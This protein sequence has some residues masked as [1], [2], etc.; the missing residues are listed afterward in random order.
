MFYLYHRIKNRAN[1]ALQKEIMEHKVTVLKLNESE[2]KFRKLAEKSRQGIFIVQEERFTYV[3]PTLLVLF[4]Y[5]VEE[6]LGRNPL[7]FVFP[8]DRPHMGEYIRRK[9]TGEAEGS[10]FQFRGVTKKGKIVYMESYGTQTMYR[11]KIS[12]IGTITDITERKKNEAELV[13]SRK[14]EAL[15]IL[16]GGVAHDF[17]NLLGVIVGYLSMI[18]EQKS[19]QTDADT[20]KMVKSVERAV[21]QSVDLAAKFLDLSEGWWV[22]RR[23]LTFNELLDSV[24]DRY[25]GI[26][27]LLT[28]IWTEPDLKSFYGDERRLRDVFYNLVKNADEAMSDPKELS[29]RGQNV[30]LDDMNDHSLESGEYIQ[31]TFR[32]NGKGIPRDHLERVFDPYFST[33]DEHSRKGMGLGLAICNSILEKHKG[34]IAIKSREGEGTTVCIYIPTF[35]Q[36]KKETR[37]MFT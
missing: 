30:D 22:N 35:C 17:N 27:H 20:F 32:D 3:N 23:A 37:M 36:E 9:F 7:D 2:E 25:P 15:G 11:G 19:I 1:Q 5:S 29:I 34:H 16:A 26:S 12:L 8:G 18:K 14:T 28:D 13:R 6:V 4:G 10:H 24:T 21:N 31:L 33:K